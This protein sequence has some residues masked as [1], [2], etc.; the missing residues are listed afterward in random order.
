[1]LIKAFKHIWVPRLVGGEVGREEL[2]LPTHSSRFRTWWRLWKD[3]HYERAQRV[4]PC[5]AW[6]G[7]DWAEQSSGALFMWQ[8]PAAEDGPPV[9]WESVSPSAG[10][11]QATGLCSSATRDPRMEP[12]MH[13]QNALHRSGCLSAVRSNLSF[14]LRRFPHQKEQPFSVYTVLPQSAYLYLTS[15]YMFTSLAN[16]TP[17]RTSR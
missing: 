6:Q 13:T 8:L 12:R 4:L 16:T 5:Q 3:I 9:P 15:R 2:G 7:A 1:M 14:L 17:S 11:S 10:H